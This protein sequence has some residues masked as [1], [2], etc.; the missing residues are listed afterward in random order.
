MANSPAVSSKP[1][2]KRLALFL[3]GT[4]NVVADNTNVWR[5]KSLC[6]PAGADGVRQLIYYNAGVGTQFGYRIRGGMLGYGL[7]DVVIESYE[8]LIDH[9]EAGRRHFHFRVQPRGIYRQEPGWPDC[10]MRTAQPRRAAGREADLFAVSPGVGSENLVGVICGPRGRHGG[11]PVGRRAMDAQIFAAGSDQIRWRVG[12]GRR[13]G[14]SGISHSRAQPLDVRI[15]AH[16][17]AA[18]GRTRLSR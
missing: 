16:R 10:K 18:A 6:A 2:K 9:Y 1:E 4:W 8:W 13:A 11:N 15:S 7:D 17:V 5:T 12:H 3:D 14:R